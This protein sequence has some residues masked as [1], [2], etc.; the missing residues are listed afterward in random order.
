MAHNE[1]PIHRRIGR[2]LWEPRMMFC[3][4]R[5]LSPNF[6]ACY[7]YHSSRG[8]SQYNHELGHISEGPSDLG[9]REQWPSWRTDRRLRNHRQ[10]SPWDWSEAPKSVDK[11]TL[12]LQNDFQRAWHDFD[13]GIANIVKSNSDTTTFLQN[14]KQRWTWN[15]KGYLPFTRQACDLT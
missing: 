1:N 3:K 8:Q 15:V 7:D 4:P 2:C 14:G 6:E 11:Q 12:I 10:S 9:Y 5:T 13:L